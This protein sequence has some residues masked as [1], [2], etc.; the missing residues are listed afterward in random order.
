[1]SVREYVSLCVSVW[2]CERVSVRL[3][4][5]VSASA[6]VRVCESGRVRECASE[7]E[8][9]CVSVSV[10]IDSSLDLSHFVSCE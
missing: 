6:S 2:A 9:A 7:R 4:V 5:S 1:M 10:Y 8:S 3:S